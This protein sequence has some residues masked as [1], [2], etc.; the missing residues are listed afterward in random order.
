MSFTWRNT[1][2]HRVSLPQV[3]QLVGMSQKSLL[4]FLNQCKWTSYWNLFLL[5][6]FVNHGRG[7]LHPVNTEEG[8]LCRSSQEW[9]CLCS[10]GAGELPETLQRAAAVPVSC[11]KA[12][13]PRRQLCSATKPPAAHSGMVGMWTQGGECWSVVWVRRLLVVSRCWQ[14]VNPWIA[15]IQ[16]VKVWWCQ[17]LLGV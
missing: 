9:T 14:Q 3:G 12:R 8:S 2:P 15:S 7:S 13:P 1:Q 17:T 10:C 6:W 11:P 16:D 4:W 5:V